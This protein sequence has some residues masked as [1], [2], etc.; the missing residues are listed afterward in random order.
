[1]KYHNTSLVKS[2][3]RLITASLVAAAGF[4][5]AST[6]S[7]AYI[8][9]NQYTGIDNANLNQGVDNV[10]FNPIGPNNQGTQVL[11]AING[12]GSNFVVQFNSTSNLIGDGGQATISGL[13]E[14]QFGNLTIS[15]QNNATF[16][17]LIVNPFV[18]PS[19]NVVFTVNY[20]N[21]MGQFLS[22]NLN[23]G[24]NGQNYHT[25][26]ALNGAML[27]SVSMVSGG[28]AMF[29]SVRQIRVG[30]FERGPNNRVPDGGT[31]LASLGFALLGL[32]SIRKLVNSK[33]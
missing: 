9:F 6:A 33:A 28:G 19:G 16:K 10:L 12:Q 5:T 1:M 27:T 2:L 21:P 7:A 23:L 13:N 4:S 3:K 30:G 32:G 20:I 29:D 8:S 24:N 31:T 26:D 17:R 22:Q 25:I 15:L 11:G 18:T 14:T